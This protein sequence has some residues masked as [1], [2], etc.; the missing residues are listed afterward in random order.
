[1]NE[2]KRQLQAQAKRLQAQYNLALA[3][4]KHLKAQAIYKQL[5]DLAFQINQLNKRS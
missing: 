1:M 2:Q 5:Q 3:Q 4:N